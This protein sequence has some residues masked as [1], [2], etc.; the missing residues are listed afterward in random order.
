MCDLSCLG[1]FT[2]CHVLEL[3]PCCSTLAL[4]SFLLRVIF[5]WMDTSRFLD[6]F[7]SPW[8]F[9]PL[10]LFGYSGRVYSEYG[11]SAHLG[12]SV[13]F[14]PKRTDVFDSQGTPRSRLA[15]SDGNSVF[16]LF[17]NCFPERLP[18]ATAFGWGWSGD[19]C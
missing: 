2:E 7:I 1:L 8:T 16:E 13:C 19:P 14:V 10:P 3:R 18:G 11:A 4:H 6:P 9:A 5:H 15:G 17:R 12:T